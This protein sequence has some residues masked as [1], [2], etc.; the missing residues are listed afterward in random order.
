MPST[1]RES[2]EKMAMD[3]AHGKLITDSKALDSLILNYTWGWIRTNTIY[4]VKPSEDALPR[5][6]ICS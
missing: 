6:I 4:T 3:K 5:N 2:E 1:K